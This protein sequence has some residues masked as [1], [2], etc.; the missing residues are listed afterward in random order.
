MKKYPS[1]KVLDLNQPYVM[2]I[3]DLLSDDP[4]LIGLLGSS[5]KVVAAYDRDAKRV[6]Y[7]FRR[8]D[9]TEPDEWEA[10][11]V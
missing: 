9:D 5:F 6:T 3:A 10:K 2:R 8:L 11:R 1:P 7:S 4:M